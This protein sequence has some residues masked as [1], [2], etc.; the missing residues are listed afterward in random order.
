[1]KD[2]EEKRSSDIIEIKGDHWH[3]N[4]TTKKGRREIGGER[5]NAAFRLHSE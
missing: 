5:V 4:E 3:N 2:R 1:M